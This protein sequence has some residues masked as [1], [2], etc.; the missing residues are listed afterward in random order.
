[1]RHLNRHIPPAALGHLLIL[2]IGCCLLLGSGLHL[3]DGVIAGSGPAVHHHD[4]HI[5]PVQHPADEIA[6]IPDDRHRH[7]VATVSFDATLTEHRGE[8]RPGKNVREHIDQPREVSGSAIGAIARFLQAE[9]S[10]PQPP[11]FSLS[12]SGRAPP[13]A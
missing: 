2:A 12:L 6:P 8:A 5:D 11:G 13:I 4:T 10:P 3:H 7:Q 9:E 1:M